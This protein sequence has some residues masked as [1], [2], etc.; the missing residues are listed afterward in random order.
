MPPAQA[1]TDGISRP[2]WTGLPID[3]AYIKYTES[4]C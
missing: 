1:G 4:S 2:E 3:E